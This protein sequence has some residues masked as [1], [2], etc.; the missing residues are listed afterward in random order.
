MFCSS[1]VTTS[2]TDHYK[3]DVTKSEAL[4]SCWLFD[5]QCFARSAAWPFSQHR[6]LH[7]FLLDLL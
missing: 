7:T 5:F 6:N 2:V 1:N 4:Q 3:L